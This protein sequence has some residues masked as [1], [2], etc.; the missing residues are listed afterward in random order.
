MY[1]A[2]EDVRRVCKLTAVSLLP[3]AIEINKTEFALVIA[4]GL[5]IA[6]GIFVTVDNA[7]VIAV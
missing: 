6:K 3:N 2:E 1:T 4:G 5:M 7:V